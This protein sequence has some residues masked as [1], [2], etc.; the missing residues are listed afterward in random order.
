M[1]RRSVRMK[2][3][4][5]AVAL[6]TTLGA[7]APAI[8]QESA[9]AGLQSAAHAAPGD[10]A[11]ALALGRALR[12]AGRATPALSELRRGIAL[13]GAHPDLLAALH[14]EVARTL[15]DR[16]D[17]AATMTECKVLG[18]LPGQAAAGHACAADAHLIWQRSTEALG[19]VALALAKDPHSYEAKLAEGRAYDLALDAAK[20]EAAFRAALAA[21]ADGVDAHV[22]LGRLLVRTG[23]RDDGVG[24]LRRA[25]ALDPDGPDALF[26]LGA[27]LAPSDE[28]VQLMAHATAGRPVFAEA[29]LA[30]GD[31][32][33]ATGHAAEAR[34]AGDMA[35]KADGTSVGPYVL[36]GKV[37][38][39]ENRPDDAIHAGEAALKIVANCAPAKLL[40]ADGD[41]KKG[42]VDLAL[43]AYQAA[44]GLDHGDPTPLVHASE[45][46]HAAGRD[47]SAQAFGMK[48]VQEFPKWGPAWAALGDALVGRG[49]KPGARDAYQ[50]A[51]AA[52]GPVD[53]DAVQRKLGAVR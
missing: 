32:L 7:Q 47:T 39:A 8:A 1:V 31:Q 2:V 5:F 50:K 3:L 51:L 15:S 30:L 20:S 23:H 44:W 21:S 16:R 36:L 22:G 34:H 27:A 4:G 9:V 37:A 43:E 24:E 48:A 12:R 38:L 26:A 19:E 42:D 18:T 29:W 40:I 49:D 33:L 41:A 13:S 17:F 6:V 52:D 10:P 14:W 28:S 25:V 53:K 35:L 46:S 11:A 45:A